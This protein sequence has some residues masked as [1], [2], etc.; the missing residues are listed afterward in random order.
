MPTIQ[1]K[2]LNVPN[3]TDSSHTVLATPRSSQELEF[4]V[5]PF[6]RTCQ[7][8]YCYFTRTHSALLCPS[9][10]PNIIHTPFL[11]LV[12][13]P[14]HGAFDTYFYYYV[15]FPHIKITQGI[16]LFACYYLLSIMHHTAKQI[17]TQAFLCTKVRRPLRV[18]KQGSS[19][20]LTFGKV[21]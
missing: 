3:I 11:H 16:S 8:F 17:F 13:L 1:F 20:M 2:K 4:S 5:R 9:S 14:Q 19:K 10:H 21:E 6:T 15:T 7:C 12:L 18:E